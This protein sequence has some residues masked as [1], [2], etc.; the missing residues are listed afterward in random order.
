MKGRHLPIILCLAGALG[1]HHFVVDPGVEDVARHI[2]DAT[3]PQ[4]AS[5]S[6]AEAAD[7]KADAIGAAA[8]ES[9]AD[10]ANAIGDDAPGAESTAGAA[11]AADEREK[12][13]AVQGV[14][15]H[16]ADAPAAKTQSTE[17]PTPA[18]QAAQDHPLAV[19][20]ETE[21]TGRC[22]SLYADFLY[23][24]V[25]GENVPFAQIR[26]DV[27]P[28][29]VPRGP[30][31]YVDPHHTPGFRLGAARQL[32]DQNELHARFSW[33]QTG[34]DSH[35]EVP[36][37]DPFVIHALTTFPTTINAAADSLTADA[38]LDIQHYIVDVDLKRMLCDSDSSIL[39][40]VLGVR[41]AHL[42]QDFQA[43]YSLLGTTDVTS[44][45]DFDGFGPRLGLDGSFGQRVFVYGRSDVSLLFGHFGANYLQE[46]V[47]SGVQAQTQ[48]GDDRVV[49]VWETELGVGWRS[50]SGRL[51]L[52]AG[53]T[54]AFWFNTMTTSSWIEGVQQSAFSSSGDSQRESLTFDGFF[55]RCGFNF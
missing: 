23:M 5:P 32:N 9:E 55:L 30:V 4:G 13:A 8:E 11:K 29:A 16:V 34:A 20:H 17:A 50:R 3:A 22:W 36:A 38:H 25:R 41:Y 53:Y 52:T 18:A 46:N 35:F 48:V 37:G 15:A 39:N 49:P 26:D 28:L 2:P 47:F 1:C 21:G 27:G 33:W 42:D 40:L 31:G 19:A 44:R 7:A 45:I 14:A 51:E 43:T 54:A 10:G 12:G 6:V 24:T